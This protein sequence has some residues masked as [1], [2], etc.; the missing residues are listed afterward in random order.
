[1]HIFS[2]VTDAAR[3]N[4]SEDRRSHTQ[5]G[6]AQLNMRTHDLHQCETVRIGQTGHV[7]AVNSL[8]WERQRMHE[9]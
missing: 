3:G 6:S 7:Q 8:D 4:A 2:S 9:P 1:M 5:D